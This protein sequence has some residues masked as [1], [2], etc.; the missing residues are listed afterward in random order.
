MTDLFL[1]SLCVG[2]TGNPLSV[3]R[4]IKGQF[5][6]SV[7]GL[8]LEISYL[9]LGKFRNCPRILLFRYHTYYT[10]GNLLSV[11]WEF[12]KFPRILCFFVPTHHC[13]KFA[14]CSLSVS[15]KVCRKSFFVRFHC[16]RGCLIF[17]RKIIIISRWWK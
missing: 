11:L 12:L 4:I 6:I 15:S 14:K 1:V 3:L 7:L 8:Q 5:T 13:W 17:S 10:A 9:F 16:A 2:P